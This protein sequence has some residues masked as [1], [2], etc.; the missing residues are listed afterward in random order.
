MAVPQPYDNTPYTPET[1]PTSQHPTRATTSQQCTKIRNPYPHHN[2]LPVPQPQNNAPY[3]CNPTTAPYLCHKAFEASS[4]LDIWRGPHVTL[5][6][7]SHGRIT[8]GNLSWEEGTCKH[9]LSAPTHIFMLIYPQMTEVGVIHHLT[10][11]LSCFAFTVAN[12][13]V[14]PFVNPL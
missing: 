5:Y 7:H 4:S 6:P 11:S 1:L 2:T 8:T 13:Q 14:T 12:T 3:S 10:L 9:P